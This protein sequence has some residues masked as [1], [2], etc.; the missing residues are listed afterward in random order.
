MT[1]APPVP[2]PTKAPPE[3]APLR[4][5]PRVKAWLNMLF[6]DHSIFRFFFNLRQAIAPG[7][8]RSSH[9]MPY[10]LRRAA[11][12]GIKTVLNL[13][14]AQASIGSNQLEWDTAARCRLKVVHFP[15]GSRDSPSR[16]EILGLV[17]AF[18]QAEYPLLLHCKSGADRAGFA[19]TVYQL[20]EAG[21]PLPEA[22][23]ELRFWW[24]GHVR[25]AKT[26]I[27]DHFFDCYAEAQQRSGTAFLDWVC[28]DYDRDAV[29]LSFRQSWW[30]TVLIDKLL[31]RE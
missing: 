26:G 19:S 15:M 24:H 18:R 9:P 28:S 22:R 1:S 17:Q 20:V 21:K 2:R 5:W 29:R 6:V 4:G 23:H 25:Q 7:V 12:A 16:S 3:V 31:R 27:L 13:R 10:Q 11:R 30:A 14:D 8:Y